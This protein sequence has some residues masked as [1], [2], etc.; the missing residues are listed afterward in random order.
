MTYLHILSFWTRGE[1][2]FKRLFINQFIKRVI[3]LTPVFINLYLQ[4]QINFLNIDFAQLFNCR[5]SDFFDFSSAFA[6]YD[7]FLTVAFNTKECTNPSFFAVVSVLN[8]SNININRMRNLILQ[9]IYSFT[10]NNFADSECQ[11]L[12]SI[13]IFIVHRIPNRRNIIQSL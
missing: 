2:I 12:V 4:I 13:S 9:T 1:L 3:P 5:K 11:I 10:T 7:A 6:D 8:I